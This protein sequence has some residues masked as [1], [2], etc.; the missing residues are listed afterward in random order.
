MATLSES[1]RRHFRYFD[2][3]LLAGGV[4]LLFA[5]FALLP[6]Q[7]PDSAAGTTLTRE[8]A[9]EKGAAL[10]LEN[11]FL[12]PSSLKSDARLA[13]DTRL[14]DSLQVR[15]GRAQAV[16]LLKDTPDGPLP[17][18]YWRVDWM[19]EGEERDDGVMRVDLSQDGRLYAFYSES[20][21][22]PIR[23][24]TREAVAEVLHDAAQGAEVPRTP[25]EAS[26]SALVALLSFSLRQAD[27]TRLD[28][29]PLA[30]P[31]GGEGAGLTAREALARN[32]PVRLDARAAAVYAQYH[33]RRTVLRDVVFRVDSV[34]ATSRPGL[35]LATVYLSTP[36]PYYGQMVEATVEVSATGGLLGLQPRFQP[37]L[38]AMGGGS[39]LSDREGFSLNVSATNA[40]DLIMGV[41]YVGLALLALF[42][43]I[44]RLNAR[45]VDTK[46]ALR[47]A[48]WAGCFSGGLVL[49]TTSLTLFDT[50]PQFWLAFVILSVNVSISGLGGAFLVF[51]ASGSMDSMARSV[52]GGKLMT[53]GL[54]RHSVFRN[55]PVGA[56][57][58]RGLFAAFV[59]V[60]GTTLL[61]GLLPEASIN[62]GS[63][64]RYF[65]HSYMLT[66][67]GYAFAKH[68]WLSLFL[69]LTVLL[70][71]GSLLYRLRASA[72]LV[73]PVT[74]LVL[75]L[76]QVPAFQVEPMGRHAVFSGFAAFVLAYTFW[77]YDFI[78]TFVALLG[79]GL[80]WETQTGWLVED[81]PDRL[82]AILAFL[83]LGILFVVGLVGVFSRRTETEVPDYLPSYIQELAQEE[84]LKGEIEIAYQVQASFLPR[85]MPRVDGVDLAAMCLPALDVGGDYY[86]FVEVSPGRLAVVVGDVSGKGIQAAF[87]MTLVKGFLLPLSRMIDSPAEV[88]RRLNGLFCENA[89][90]GTFIS[91]IYGV[92]DVEART[93]T[94]VRAGHN[95]VILK[96]SPSQ[97]PEMFRPAGLAIGLTAGPRFDETIVE[98]TIHLRPGD[99]LVFYT[100]G[101]SEAMNARKELYG[102]V[103]LAQRVSEVG[104]RSANEILRAVSEDVHHF[105]EAAGRHDDMTMVVL[106]L[107]SRATFTPGEK[108]AAAAAS[109]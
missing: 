96:R 46:T 55:V 30:V 97:D 32:V 69:N 80:L 99:V 87:Y 8:K 5:Y 50:I 33:L 34:K 100:D 40:A 24:V 58:L 109:A 93:F 74:T 54:V 81:A 86:D 104:Q 14:L 73:V 21:E 42:L 41:L 22:A 38:E 15:Y 89:P 49:V 10:V 56:A 88:L 90:R 7:H 103:R 57:L 106:K 44:R 52:W 28:A 75:L 1:L 26:D 94:F 48:F 27:S 45:L 20:S 98:E 62:Y 105:M 12:L 36:T 67:A 16:Q 23:R 9:I 39:R 63:G 101:F 95:P 53:L 3:L 37:R 19:R 31:V 60:G 92:F 108:V 51:L 61:L 65:N 68:A 11:G 82:D 71:L 83:F 59:L 43:F 35:P 25:I 77:R 79:F 13:R 17:A 76:L 72:W 4:S 18:F 29:D 78:T 47:D 84:R 85:R 91:M 107:R 2:V 102:D 70:G 66:T 6:G 64:D